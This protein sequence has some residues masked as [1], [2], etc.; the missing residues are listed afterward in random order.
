MAEFT[1]QDSLTTKIANGEINFSTV[2]LKVML[3][4]SGYSYDSSD[5]TVAD[6][7]S[8][9]CSGSNYS[10]GGITLSNVG[11]STAS[12]VATVVA[13]DVVIAES[14]TG[15]TDCKY[16]C[17]LSGS[18]LLAV[19]T[20]PSAQTNQGVELTFRFSENGLFTIT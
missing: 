4:D 6:V 18:N 7:S 16:I 1:K 9:E 2:T 14:S 13:D 11:V 3:V 5:S 15:F 17:L 19:S 20:I 10:S 8:Y 12:G